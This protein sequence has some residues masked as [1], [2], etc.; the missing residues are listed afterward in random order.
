MEAFLACAAMEGAHCRGVAAPA[1]VA[2][3]AVAVVSVLAAL[4]SATVVLAAF[5]VPD[6]AAK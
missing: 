6:A 5:P 1:F 2:G 4:V 3:F